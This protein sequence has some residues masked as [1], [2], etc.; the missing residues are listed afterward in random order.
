MFNALLDQMRTHTT[1][2]LESRRAELIDEQRRLHTEELAIVR[3]LD[4]R[5]RIDVSIGSEGESAR[6]VRDKVE[7]ARALESLPEIATAA[8]DGRLSDEQL[9][10]VVRL[11][12]ELTDA[13]WARRA[14][15]TRPRPWRAWH[16]T[17]R[18]R[19]RTIRGRASPHG[20]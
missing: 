8:Y 20:P 16:G 9:S 5:G 19:R 10:Q 15:N 12:D 3:V 2:W 18:S 14:P 17:P 11:A 6:V 1:A 13:D 4:E 7:T